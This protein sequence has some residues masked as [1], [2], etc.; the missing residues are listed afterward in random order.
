MRI[1]QREKVWVTA[2]AA[3]I[4][5]AFGYLGIIYPALQRIDR[6]DDRIRRKKEILHQILVL[7]TEWNRIQS[8]RQF[9]LQKI[10]GRGRDFSM[11]RH[12][13]E[14]ARS[15]GVENRIQY[16]RPLP[17][18]EATETGQLVRNG[19]EVKLKKVDL[20]GLIQYLYR[21]EYSDKLLMVESIHIKPVYTNPN[22]INVTF[23]VL[24]LKKA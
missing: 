1:S 6:L 9:I 20:A 21:I 19:L 13:E 15:A 12:M 2:G 4:L 22:A 10:E 8:E 23:R 16:M 24:T 5:L 7:R 3:V 18:E 17:E 14:L 11:F